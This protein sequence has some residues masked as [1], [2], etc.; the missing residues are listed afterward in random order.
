VRPGWTVLPLAHPDNRA[1]GP[2]ERT[3][4]VSIE[5]GEMSPGEIS[6]RKGDRVTLS[7]ELDESLELHVHGYDVEREI[8]PGEPGRLSFEADLTGR[9]EIE[10]HETKEEVGEL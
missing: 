2:Q 5:D 1:A 3:F 8:G 4:E 6:A 7:I 10:N 9:F